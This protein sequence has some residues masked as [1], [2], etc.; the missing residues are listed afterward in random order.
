MPIVYW[1]RIFSFLELIAA[2]KGTRILFQ[3]STLLNGD[4]LFLTELIQ[5]THELKASESQM[6]DYIQLG[7]NRLYVYCA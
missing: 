4:D 3:I 2:P 7:D 5:A 1:A 6:G